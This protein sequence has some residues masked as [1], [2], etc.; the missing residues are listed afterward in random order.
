MKIQYISDLHLD[1]PDNLRFFQTNRIVPQADILVL[2]GDVIPLK[3]L[4]LVEGFLDNLSEDFDRVYWVP[5]N[6]EYYGLDYNIYRSNFFQSIRDN[7]FIV[8]NKSILVNDV[9]LIFSTLWSEI[10]LED[11]WHSQIYIN[12]FKFVKFNTE[13][14]DYKDYNFFNSECREY[15][16]NRICDHSIDKK[17][18]ITHH[19]PVLLP[20]ELLSIDSALLGAYC[21]DLAGLISDYRPNFWI[22]GHTHSN[23]GAIQIGATSYVTNQ[24]NDIKSSF[25]N[26]VAVVIDI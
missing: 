12:D 2:A 21:N 7:V 15:I 3:D 8:N 20:S 6:H 13:A 10:S 23:V 16:K 4:G 24:F 17:V 18:V 22:Y 11:R 1:N 19:C 25:N 14:I 5:G 26:N 9:E